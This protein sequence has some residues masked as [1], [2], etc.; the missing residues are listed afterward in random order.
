MRRKKRARREGQ[1]SLAAEP[2]FG[3]SIFDTLILTGGAALTVG[4]KKKGPRNEHLAC[5]AHHVVHANTAVC[6]KDAAFRAKGVG[7]TRL[8]LGY[9]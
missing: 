5:L 4:A 3:L 9:H 8:F 7:P 2:L 1:R 6:P